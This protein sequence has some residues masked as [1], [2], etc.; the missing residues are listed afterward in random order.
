M[1]KKNFKKRGILSLASIK[2]RSFDES[3]VMQCKNE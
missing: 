1:N 2:K 3:G